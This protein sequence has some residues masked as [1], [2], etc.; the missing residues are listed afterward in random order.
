MGISSPPEFLARLR[1]LRYLLFKPLVQGLFAPG[2]ISLD[3][4]STSLT[5]WKLNTSPRAMFS[6]KLVFSSAGDSEY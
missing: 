3:I 6:R 2:R 4:L 1:C 5:L